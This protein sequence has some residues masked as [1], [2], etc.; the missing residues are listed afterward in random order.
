LDPILFSLIKANVGFYVE[1]IK[2]HFDIDLTV[3]TNMVLLPI[4]FIRP[5]SPIDF[6]SSESSLSDSSKEV[7]E[8]IKGIVEAS[9]RLKSA[10]IEDSILVED[11]L[12]NTIFIVSYKNILLEA[13]KAFSDFKQDKK[14]IT[15]MKQIKQDPNLHKTKY[16]DPHNP[17]GASKDWYSKEIFVELAK[18]YHQKA[19]V[20][21]KNHSDLRALLRKEF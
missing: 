2:K 12:F 17:K 6:L 16:L 7:K 19:K 13:K 9:K 5:F 18:Y 15:L 3:E 10:N 1:F 21:H 4:G 20:L 8:F 14:F 11:S